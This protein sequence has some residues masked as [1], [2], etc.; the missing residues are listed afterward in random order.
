MPT[1]IPAASCV[2]GPTQGAGRLEGGPGTLL[3]FKVTFPKGKIT[4]RRGKVAL[5]S[6]KVR[7]ACLRMVRKNPK[8]NGT[9]RELSGL[10]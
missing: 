4:S 6:G 10:R 1:L 7:L 9:Q 2:A 3:Y 8:G 5:L